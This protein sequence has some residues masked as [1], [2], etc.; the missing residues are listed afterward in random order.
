MDFDIDRL[1]FFLTH[2]ERDRGGGG[3]RENNRSFGWQ[4]TTNPHFENNSL[5]HIRV[6]LQIKSSKCCREP[7]GDRFLEVRG[8]LNVARVERLYRHTCTR[9]L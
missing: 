6:R 2:K 5:R 7:C 3:R 8:A 9:V 1:N 4:S